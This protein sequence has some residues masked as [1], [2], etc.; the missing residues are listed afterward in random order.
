VAHLAKQTPQ[1][2]PLAANDSSAPSS[3]TA[4]I[5]LISRKRAWAEKIQTE[6]VI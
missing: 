4:V 3:I 6:L 2:I 1:P 5:L